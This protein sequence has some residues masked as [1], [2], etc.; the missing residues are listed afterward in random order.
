MA[1]DTFHGPIS[2]EEF[3]Y[4]LGIWASVLAGKLMVTEFDKIPTDAGMLTLSFPNKC[5]QIVTIYRKPGSLSFKALLAIGKE[6][7]QDPEKCISILLHCV[8]FEMIIINSIFDEYID[9]KSVFDSPYLDIIKDIPIKIGE[10]TA[11]DNFNW[12]YILKKFKI[13]KKTKRLQ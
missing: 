1:D 6:F 9:D 11:I 5:G 12:E 7:Y 4:A 10:E 3:K 8:I 2:I 13:I